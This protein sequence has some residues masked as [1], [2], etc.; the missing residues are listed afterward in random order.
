MSIEKSGAA[1]AEFVQES[2]DALSVAGQ[3]LTKTAIDIREARE[4]LQ[5]QLKEM[6]VG[7]QGGECDE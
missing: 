7:A 5:N 6:S 4:H 2:L 3:Q 1:Y